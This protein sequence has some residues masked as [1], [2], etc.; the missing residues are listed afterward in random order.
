[1]RT[2][3]HRVAHLL[4][5][6]VRA[7]RILLLTFTRRAAQEM[8][9]RVERLVGSVSRQVHGGTFHGTGHRLLR[10]FGSQAGIGNDFTILDQEDA[11]DLMHFARSQ[12]TP[13][14]RKAKRFPK[15]ET[16]HH[17]YSRH[18][19]TDMPVPDILAEEYPQFEEFAAS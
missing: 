16:L 3:V 11:V 17:V 4:D 9:A 6:G 13:A 15:K 2:L 10:R 8:L 5:R 1:T 7:D 14:E 18:I 12:L 19:N